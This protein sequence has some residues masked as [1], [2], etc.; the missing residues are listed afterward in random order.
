[1]S[2]SAGG[3]GETVES[4]LQ[5]VAT[6]VKS[7]RAQIA[8]MRLGKTSSTWPQILGDFMALCR[9]VNQLQAESAGLLRYN[10]VFPSS[11]DQAH[12]V[13]AFDYL[14]M[15]LSTAEDVTAQREIEAAR[16]AAGLDSVEKTD[17]PSSEATLTTTTGLRASG[18]STSK[19]DNTQSLDLVAAIVE[20]SAKNPDN[21][22]LPE[23]KG[24]SDTS[25]V[26]TDRALRS[27][28][29]LHNQ[30]CERMALAYVFDLLFIDLR[31]TSSSLLTNTASTVL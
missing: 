21:A 15:L 12:A 16:V 13:Q 20:L 3:V 1:M 2:S 28:V 29:A 8:Q 26:S 19:N 17:L 24:R 11:F 31:T 14:P 22:L 5:R 25:E 4:K 30:H 7:V 27:C 6:R 9:Q 10:V 23:Y 18:S